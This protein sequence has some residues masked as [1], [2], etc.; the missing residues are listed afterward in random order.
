MAEQGIVDN[1]VRIA[2]LDPSDDGAIRQSA[3]LLL[4]GF[5]EVAPDA[6]ADLDAALDEVR[7]AL[8]PERV[9]LAAFDADGRVAGWIGSIPTYGHAWELHPLVVA[10]AMQGRGVGRALVEA[11][12]E[13]LRARG[14]LTLYLGT[15]D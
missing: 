13:V 3:A 5:T 4:E 11:L 14:V 15:D 1:G 2:P 9:C 8:D 7:Q 6:W 10:P 12:E